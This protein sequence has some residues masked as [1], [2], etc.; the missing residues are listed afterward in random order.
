VPLKAEPTGASKFE[1]AGLWQLEP[2]LGF[3][4]NSATMRSKFLLDNEI[5]GWKKS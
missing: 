3:K 5:I 4:V 2:K 1:G